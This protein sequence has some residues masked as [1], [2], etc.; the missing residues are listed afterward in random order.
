M[1]GGKKRKTRGIR[2]EGA[3]EG[4]F[5]P[6]EVD[7]ASK[8]KLPGAMEAMEANILAELKKVQ[9]NLKGEIAEK[10]GLVKTEMSE[11]RKEVGQRLDEIVTD[12]KEVTSRIEEVEQRVNE[13]EEVTV[14]LKDVLGHT[15]QLQEDLQTRLSDLEARSRRNNIRVHGIPEGEEGDNMLEFMENFIK[16]E[17]PLPD[18]NLGIQRCHRSLG[19]KPPPGSNPRSVVIHFL[20]YKI[21]DLVLRSAWTK[22]EIRLKGRRVYFDQDY[23]SDILAK[24]KAYNTIRRI[25]KEKGLRFQT[26]YPSRLRVFYESGPVI[27]NN[28][29][30][31]SEDLEKRKLMEK[32]A[33]DPI[34]RIP[35]L[36]PRTPFWERASGAPRQTREER[37]KYIQEKLQRFKC[38]DSNT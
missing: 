30:D 29:Q 36:K 26:L 13:V 23:P 19:P 17:L 11:F 21:K 28:A 8:L 4:V 27:Y 1:S 6:K 20:E 35:A 16:K 32:G 25:L 10:I 31:A 24:R 3:E 14:D 18:T 7:G 34:P 5:S 15:L 9:D 12:M 37:M 22:K 38:M 33:D 2:Q